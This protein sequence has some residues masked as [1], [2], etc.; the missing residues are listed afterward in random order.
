MGTIFNDDFRDFIQALNDHK[1]EY[2]LVGGYA[3]I[4]NNTTF[5]RKIFVSHFS[6]KTIVL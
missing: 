6:R 3:V 4:L 2:I 1:V 5:P